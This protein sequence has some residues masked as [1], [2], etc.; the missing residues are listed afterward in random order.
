LL[1]ELELHDAGL[2]RYSGR[3]VSFS[4]SPNGKRLTAHFR[5]E[6]RRKTISETYPFISDW[7]EL[8]DAWNQLHARV[9]AFVADELDLAIVTPGYFWNARFHGNSLLAGEDRKRLRLA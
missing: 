5:P 2:T 9:R 6:G 1:T 4:V 8:V 7:N 3:N